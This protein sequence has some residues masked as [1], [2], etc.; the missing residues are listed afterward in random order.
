MGQPLSICLKDIIE[1]ISSSGSPFLS[2]SLQ[3][4]V[5]M[6]TYYG[7]FN[8]YVQYYNSPVGATAGKISNYPWQDY[9]YASSFGNWNHGDLLS[10][11]ANTLYYLSCTEPVLFS[12]AAFR[13][14][15]VAMG[16][17]HQLVDRHTLAASFYTSLYLRA[18][19]ERQLSV[20]QYKDYTC[21]SGCKSNT[22]LTMNKQEK[23]RYLSS[24]VAEL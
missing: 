18:F 1:G 19:W 9:H 13:F 24:E 8:G 2:K 7:H 22:I 16:N 6:S 10:N 4:L 15:L 3:H 5:E 11:F 14:V 12:R 20:V 23:V 21:I 17:S